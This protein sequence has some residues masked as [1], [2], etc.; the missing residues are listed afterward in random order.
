[1]IIKLNLFNSIYYLIK[2]LKMEWPLLCILVIKIK[3][4]IPSNYYNT[5]SLTHL[6]IR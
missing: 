3:Y 2:M 1:M 6:I 5:L 4:L